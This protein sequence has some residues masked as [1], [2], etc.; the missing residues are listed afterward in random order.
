MG[1]FIANITRGTSHAGAAHRVLVFTR[2]TEFRVER[3]DCGAEIY[4]C[5]MWFHF[6][7]MP[8]GPAYVKQFKQLLSW[9]DLLHFHYP[10]PIQDL[11]YL[12]GKPFCKM[13]PA[14]VTYH[15]DIV[16]QKL[17]GKLYMPLAMRFLRSVDKVV[18]TSPGYLESSAVLRQLNEPGMVPLGIAESLYP[19]LSTDRQAHFRERF[20][21]GYFLFLGALRY[22]KGLNW[23][24][25]AALKTGLPVVIAGGGQLAD[26]LKAQ[27]SGA[28]NIHFA[29][30]VSEEDKV[31]L[32]SLAKA[33]VFPSHLRSEAFGIS[34]LEAQMMR[35][36]LITCEIGTG[37]SYVNQHGETGLVVPPGNADA[38]AQAMLEMDSD[39]ERLDQMASASHARY[40]ELFTA[41]QMSNSYLDLYRQLI[42][43][44]A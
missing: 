16:R 12:A 6:A 37:T 19:A 44:T 7:S 34:L 39:P 15:S 13:P 18:A 14:L 28:D 2:E 3:W 31:A 26:E 42:S 27:A 17:F 22:Y 11:L 38:L 25:E 43:S 40:L 30:E 36:P 24:V 32:L 5:P 4:F 21:E 9:A 23:L 20:G 29:G 8:I 35:L 1:V 33:F 41:E 10:F